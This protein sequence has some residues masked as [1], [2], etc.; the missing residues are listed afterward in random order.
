MTVD[1]K[2]LS[3]LELERLS[4]GY[5]D[6]IADFIGP[7]VDIPAP[8]VSTNELVMG[9]MTDEYSLITRAL[10]ATSRRSR[11]GSCSG[12]TSTS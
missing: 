3:L 8:D 7:D 10:T 9:W 4:R 12:S 1:P 5:I 11:A 2:E 6:A